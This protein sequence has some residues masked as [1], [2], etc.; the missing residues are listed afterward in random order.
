MKGVSERTINW[1][2]VFGII[3][4]SVLAVMYNEQ[5][6]IKLVL[7]PIIELVSQFTIGAN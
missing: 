2:S 7:E 5:V 4:L 6:F 1:L 3:A